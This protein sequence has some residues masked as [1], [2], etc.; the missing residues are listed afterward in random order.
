[1]ATSHLLCR[2]GSRLCAFGLD[3]VSETMRPL[4][5]EAV[6]GMPPFLL[7][8]A[9]IRGAPLPVV[10]GARVLGLAHDSPPARFV[11]VK[12]AGRKAAIAVDEVVGIRTLAADTLDQL[13]PLLAGADAQ[14]VL[15]IGQLDF[16]LL[17]LLDS[18]R[19]IPESVWTALEQPCPDGPG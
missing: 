9:I 5:A 6:A 13:P 18:A 15:A 8:L 12:V 2:I 16:Q 1:M 4:P 14:A 10:D 11:V 17:L 7:G 3:Q 19:L